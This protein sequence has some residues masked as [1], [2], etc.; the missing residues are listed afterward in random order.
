[1]RIQF[2]RLAAAVAAGALLLNF[3]GSVAAASPAK[4]TLAVADTTVAPT[5]ATGNAHVRV[6]HGS[7]DAPQVDVY[8]GATLATA[9]KV[10]AL[11]GLSFGQVSSYANIPAGT[12][13]IKVCATADASVCPIQVPSLALTAE[14]YYT[15]AASS[16][17]ASIKATVFTDTPA[18]S[19]D[20]A[21]LR[22]YH[23]SSDTPAVDV[24]TSTGADINAGLD[25]LS[26]P[27]ATG[28]LVLP[29][30][31]Y[32]LEVCAHADHTV[33]PLKNV[34]L[35][36][37]ADHNYSIFAIGSLTSLLATPPPTSTIDGSTLPA[38]GGSAL[39]LALLALAFAVSAAGTLRY[40]TVR[41]RR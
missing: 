3:V 2:S 31:T 23:L 15:I 20:G 39:P 10:T 13:A 25:N 5:T 41:N 24:L 8:A 19:T 35:T 1:V 28:Y 22:V 36:V 40:A 9:A 17:L 34:A 6:V 12:Y 11:S 7:P 4:L 30:N 27:N 33:C 18:P 21:Q 16:P 29:A 32:N 14:T 26:Y 38:S 37:L